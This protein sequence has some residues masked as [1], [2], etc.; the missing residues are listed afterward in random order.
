[1]QSVHLATAAFFDRHTF[2]AGPWRPL[3]QR[4]LRNCAHQLLSGKNCLLQNQP[5]TCFLCAMVERFCPSVRWCFCPRPGLL[6]GRGFR[7]P[8]RHLVQGGHRVAE[9]LRRIPLQ[10]RVLLD[11]SWQCCHSRNRS[12]VPNR[13]LP[14][15]DR[16]DRVNDSPAIHGQVLRLG[17]LRQAASAERHDERRPGPGLDLR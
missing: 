15:S 16:F 14:S 5:R 11:Q 10:E 12:G 8:V 9:G 13:T 17:R 1:M 4:H 3:R 6:R 2:G 7:S